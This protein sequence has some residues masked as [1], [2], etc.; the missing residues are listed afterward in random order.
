MASMHPETLDKI[1][2]NREKMCGRLESIHMY[3]W[4]KVT[5]VMTLR[6][7]RKERT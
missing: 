4:T 2:H 5:K 3:T 7:V 1:S 6:Y